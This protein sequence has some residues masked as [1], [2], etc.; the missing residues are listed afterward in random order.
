MKHSSSIVSCLCE[1]NAKTLGNRV[2]LHSDKS[3]RSRKD[4]SERRLQVYCSFRRN[5]NMK[6]VFKMI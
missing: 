4:V 2:E 6:K 5:H 1:F 3:N